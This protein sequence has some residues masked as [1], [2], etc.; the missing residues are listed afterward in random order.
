MINRVLPV[1]IVLFFT[2][3][4]NGQYISTVTIP[5]STK[6]KVSNPKDLSYRYASGISPST[7][8]D[9]LRILASDSLEGRETGQ[10]GMELAA[11]YISK[12]LK[13]LGLTIPNG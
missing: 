13:N 12:V 6:P 4:M 2:L 1:V 8:R 7:L 10:K 11:D 5:D 3:V 9:H